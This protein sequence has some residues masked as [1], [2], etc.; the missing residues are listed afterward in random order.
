VSESEIVSAKASFERAVNFLRAGDP[1]TAEGLCRSALEHHADDPNLLCLLGAALIKQ[2]KA[3]E[4]EEPLRTAVGGAP[5]FAN[6]HE[7]LAESL[8]MQG[9]FEEGLQCLER[10]RELEPDRASVQLR[11]GH[12]L[13]RVGREGDAIR[14]FH[15]SFRLSPNREA[16]VKGVELHRAGDVQGAERI[17]REVLLRSPDDVDALR[18]LASVAAGARQWSDA[19]VMLKRVLE[20]A[21]DFLQAWLDLGLAQQEQER[22]EEAETSFTRAA[23]L[24]ARR[25]Q[26]WIALGTTRAMAGRHR[27]ALEAF[28]AALARNKRHPNALNGKGHV[29]KTTGAQA[30]AIAM[31]RE[32]IAHNPGNGEAYWSLA[33]LK[34]FRFTD[35]EVEAMSEQ[36]R[37]GGLADEPRVNMLFALAT[38]L[39]ARG[40]FDAAFDH[41]REGNDL[42]REREVYDPVQTRMVHD[43]FIEVFTREFVDLKQGLGH[44]SEAPIFI[45]GLPRSGST[46]VEQILASHSQVEGTHELPELSQVARSTGRGR[47]DRLSYPE[48]V[49]T[50][51]DE[52][53]AE[54]GALYLEKTARHRRRQARRFTDK[55]PNNF[56]HLGFLKLI[57]PNARIIDAQRHPLDSCLGSYKQLFARGQP[58][59]Y[60]LYEIGE[61]YLEYRRLMDHWHKV[62]PGHVLDLQYEELVT[63]T[64]R[65]VRRLLEFCGLRWEEECLRFHENPRAVR[66]AS[67]EQ[68]RRPIYTSAMHRWRDYETHLG[69]LIEVLEPVLRQLPPDRQPSA[70]RA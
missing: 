38:A 54:L 24:D 30:D 15:E 22:L 60:D 57:L 13:A 61:Y 2:N 66:T 20:L 36:L 27:E 46:L 45:V 43:Q 55:M 7:G 56:A 69:P 5:S 52:R 1:V 58:F 39:E 29:L 3:K 4:A 35:A 67:S 40:E 50:L 59:T 70:L 12:L 42:R 48:T 49:R 33:N 26:P 21:P 31:Y 6:A 41:Y 10:A 32:C 19:E 25:P 37:A 64:E 14:A 62:L 18:L 8:I 44:S 65:Q 17:Y 51:P 68:V 47:A 28:D 53:F 16:L 63:D 9:R 34:T 23:R 11:L